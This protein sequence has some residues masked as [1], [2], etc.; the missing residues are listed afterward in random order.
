M[1]GVQRVEQPNVERSIIRNFEILNIISSKD[2]LFDF[3][4]LDFFNIC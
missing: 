2:E 3:F 1:G 4:I